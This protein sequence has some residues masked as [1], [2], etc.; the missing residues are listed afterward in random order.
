MQSNTSVFGFTACPEANNSS[1]S[2]TSTPV[3]S[4]NFTCRSSNLKQE[5][6]R[7]KYLGYKNFSTLVS[8]SCGMVTVLDSIWYKITLNF[9]FTHKHSSTQ[10]VITSVL[11]TDSQRVISKIPFASASRRFVHRLHMNISFHCTSIFVESKAVFT[12]NILER[13]LY[14]PYGLVHKTLPRNENNF[15]C[16]IWLSWG[17]FFPTEN[18]DKINIPVKTICTPAISPTINEPKL[19]FQLVTLQMES[20]LLSWLRTHGLSKKWTGQ[21]RVLRNS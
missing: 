3:T 7:K 20:P 14:W 16:S 10:G 13:E 15:A 12:W 19:T 5:Q 11:K 17:F 4:D 1:C 8:W 21:F 9:P 6:K 18:F 2:L